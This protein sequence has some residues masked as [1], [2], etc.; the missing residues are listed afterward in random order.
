[1]SHFDK[2]AKTR[3][4]INTR[5][6][7]R[8]CNELV[9]GRPPYG[10]MVLSK[11]AP[12]PASIRRYTTFFR[13]SRTPIARQNVI[14]LRYT[15]ISHYQ[16]PNSPLL[17]SQGLQFRPHH[18]HTLSHG[19]NTLKGSGGIL[20]KGIETPTGLRLGSNPSPPLP[21]PKARPREPRM[22]PMGQPL[23]RVV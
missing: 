8:V 14:I 4:Q 10:K 6:L 5:R 23:I 16:K 2:I 13:V 1:M 15:T 21:P 17:D 9:F 11:K 20:K 7:T 3:A 22:G 12:P 19:I 18:P